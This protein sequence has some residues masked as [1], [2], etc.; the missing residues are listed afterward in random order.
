MTVTEA[1]DPPAAQDDLFQVTEDSTNNTLDVLVNDSTMG[2]VGETLTIVEVTNPEH[3]GTATIATDGLSLVYTPKADFFGTERF[4]YT[5]SDG[6]GGTAQ[7]SIV[8]SVNNTNDPPT[9]NADTF[10]VVKDTSANVLDVLAND[11]FAPDPLEVLTIVSV[12]NVSANATVTVSADGKHINYTP[13]AGF[14]GSDTFT[15]TM[16]DPDGATAQST[17]SV[18]VQD[19]VPSTM[20][21][22]TYIDV[23]NNGVK[24]FTESPLGGIVVRLVGTDIHGAAVEQQQTTD[25]LGFYE[26]IDLAPGSYRLI[27]IQPK[28]LIDG[29]DSAGPYG[30]SV[31]TDELAIELEQDTDATNLNFGERGRESKHISLFDFFSSTPRESVLVTAGLD[32]SEQW[33][34]VEAGWSQA[35]TLN[36]EL[37]EGQKSAKLNMTT[38]ASEDYSTTLNF[39]NQRH[40]QPLGTIGPMQLMRVVGSLA[41]V[42][43]DA[44]C[45]CTVD[46]GEG[47][48]R[49]AAAVAPF[50]G[51]AE[52]E[53]DLVGALP[54]AAVG[55]D[56]QPLY[57]AASAGEGEAVDLAALA[58]PLHVGLPQASAAAGESDTEILMAATPADAYLATDLLMAAAAETQATADASEELLALPQG[59]NDDYQPLVEAAL[60]ELLDDPSFD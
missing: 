36:V 42:F 53:A 14:T 18:T 4:M 58:W 9:A 44:D 3:G 29:I 2:D 50:S 41:V 55:Y 10:S 30:S 6:N 31:G 43:P 21:G 28:F 26:F 5:I 60:T 20:S 59:G 15:Y 57:V 45:G 48:A 38:A 24:E 19:Y 40:V 11:S 7:A 22:Y 34:A 17:V 52:G 37:E 8:V 46:G 33:Y 56:T 23:N 1:N 16:K 27:E 51:G 54:A 32:P 12:S 39:N 13:A 35:K 25:A 47:E 49:S